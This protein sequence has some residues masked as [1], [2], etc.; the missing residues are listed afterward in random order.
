MNKF[1]KSIV[2]GFVVLS[3][4]S[5]MV[6]ADGASFTPLNFDDSTSV[7]QPVT[8]TS[9]TV[10]GVEGKKTDL[11]D[12]AQVTGGSKMQDAILQIDNAQIELRN[13]LLN[14]KSNYS[15]IDSKYET[16]RAQRKEAKRQVK[17]AEKKIRNLDKAKEKIRK[18]FERRENL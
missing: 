10:S 4:S 9:K 11:L 8:T 7:K 1:L 15:E 14:Y 6:L 13:K 3:V 12:P 16:I 17:Q 2:T 18:N 5:G